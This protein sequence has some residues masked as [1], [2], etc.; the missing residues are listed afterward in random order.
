MTLLSAECARL[1]SLT[2]AWN[3]SS[4][5]SLLRCEIL[6]KSCR[7][8]QTLKLRL[9]QNFHLMVKIAHLSS[10]HHFSAFQRVAFESTFEHFWVTF[11]SFVLNSHAC[12][13][14]QAAKLRRSWGGL[15][16]PTPGSI[17]T[18][19]AIFFAVTPRPWILRKRMTFIAVMAFCKQSRGGHC[20][21]DPGFH[22]SKS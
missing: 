20:N 5:L 8:L 14:T 11:S 19:E 10:S 12:R 13:L 6:C 9:S 21:K 7:R 3:H 15:E 22:A 18:F 4:L 17:G 1:R 2:L 16:P